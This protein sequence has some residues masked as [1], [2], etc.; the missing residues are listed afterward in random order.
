MEKISLTKDHKITLYAVLIAFF[1]SILIGLISG[2]PAVVVFVRAFISALLFGAVL[3]GGL[4]LLRRYIPELEGGPERADSGEK[5]QH[6]QAEIGK[7]I[8]LSVSGEDTG[9]ETVTKT[10]A[11]QTL[12]SAPGDTGER[13]PIF[14][15]TASVAEGE[16]LSQRQRT[17]VTPERGGEAPEEEF[18]HIPDMREASSVNDLE[19]ITLEPTEKNGSELGDELPSLDRLYEE[20]EEEALPDIGP[21]VGVSRDS[22]PAPGEYIEVGDVRIPYEPEILAKAVKKVMKE[23]E[24]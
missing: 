13:T 19:G 11:Q 23:D 2:N 16:G 1:L 8:D 5:A 7:T 18:P 9:G 12:A 14:E 3:Y 22:T 10:A 4:Y 21:S 6:A 20:H 15:N 17:G 24:Y